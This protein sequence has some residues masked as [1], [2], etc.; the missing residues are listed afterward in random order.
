M[1]LSDLIPTTG[2]TNRKLK[3]SV[4]NKN[5]IK[6]I[7]HCGWTCLDYST[8]NRTKDDDT[9]LNCF[10]ECEIFWVHPA[11]PTLMLVNDSQDDV[12]V[13]FTPDDFGLCVKND[14]INSRNVKTL[15]C[16]NRDL[17]D[18]I[19]LDQTNGLLILEG[20]VAFKVKP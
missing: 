16:I 11:Y 2:K 8:P 4:W 3:C 6:F 1:K 12:D 18:K 7:E 5:F 14:F 9:I 19:E 17:A 15:F 10:D 20:C 13:P